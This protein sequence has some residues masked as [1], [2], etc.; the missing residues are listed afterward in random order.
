MK[1]LN[2][3]LSPDRK[4]VSFIN[5]QFSGGELFVDNSFQR[6]S[7]W[8]IKNKVRLIETILMMYPMPELYFWASTPRKD[9]TISNS[10][11]DGQQRIRAITEFIAGDFELKSSYLDTKNKDKPYAGCFFDDLKKKFKDRIW[12][13]Q[14]NVKTIPSDVNK[15]EIKRIFLRLNE[16]DKS[17]NPQE[18]RHAEFSGEFAKTSEKLAE[19]SFWTDWE[20]FTPAAIRRMSDVTFVSQ[21]LSYQR[22]GMEGSITPSKLTELYDLFNDE[23]KQKSD[24]IKSFKATLDV[25][26]SIFDD[27]EHAAEFFTAI[28]HFYPLY[29]VFYSLLKGADQKQLADEEIILSIAEALGSFAKAYKKGQKT[30]RG[31]ELSAYRLASNEGFNKKANRETKVSTVRAIVHGKLKES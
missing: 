10:V 13:Y 22:L 25:I 17:L 23:Y 19:L 29:I 26:D 4:V 30:Y 20:V 9:G 24:D 2:E 7:V 28:T 15:N 27:N 18:K 12:Q 3:K 16:T 6:R 31:L 1:D 21:L 11:V 14:L 8:G 5:S